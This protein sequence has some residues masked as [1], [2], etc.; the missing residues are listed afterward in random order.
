MTKLNS[1]LKFKKGLIKNVAEK[2]VAGTNM[3]GNSKNN[4]DCYL[5]R[6]F[7]LGMDFSIFGVFDGHGIIDCIKN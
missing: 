4:Q 6:R 5:A 2:T 3:D 1:I 7:I